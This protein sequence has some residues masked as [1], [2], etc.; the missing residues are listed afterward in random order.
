MRDLEIRVIAVGTGALALLLAGGCAN[1][2]TEKGQGTSASRQDVAVSVSPGDGAAQV[3]PELPVTVGA[4]GGALR[5]VTVRATTRGTVVQGVLSADRTQWRSK[6][7]MAPGESYEVTVVAVGPSGDT[8][9]VSSRFSTVRATQTYA[10]ETILPHKEL[11]GL[12]VGIG[13]PIMLTFDHPITDRVSV[14]RNLLVQSSKPV[15]GAWHWFDDKSVSFRPKRYWPAHTKVKLVAQLAGVRGGPGMYGAQDYVREFEI[16]RAQISTADVTS[17]QMTVERDGKVIRT[18][19]LSAG[20]G[21]DWKY[22]TTNGVHLAMSREDV[23]TMTSPDAGPGSPGY[24]SMTVYDTV[25]ISNSGEYVHGAPWSVGSQGNSNVSHG[26][27]NVSP[28]N[29]KWFKE[30]TLIGDPIIVSGSPRP[31]EPA[32]GWG[33]WQESWPQWLRWSGLRS[34]FTTEALSAVPVTDHLVKQDGGKDHK[35]TTTS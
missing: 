4:V 18:V 2:G 9:Q 32:N 21:G 28:E 6:R 20:R 24:Y 3:A 1:L 5:S 30:T 7:A 29:A 8:R 22:H 23:T 16:G 19:P 34:G 33:H 31:L 11:T 17:H 27:I 12:T 10:V 14:E 13:M 25:R 26:C 35:K 15:E